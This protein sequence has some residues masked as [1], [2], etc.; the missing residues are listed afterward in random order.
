M[1]MAMVMVERAMAMATRVVGE[2]QQKRWRGQ[3]LWWAIMRG[4]AT[5]MR[6]VS[7]EEGEGSKAAATVCV[8]V[9]VSG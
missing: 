3:R 9:L 7:N 5:A 1:T 8:C 6:V 4:I 2:Q